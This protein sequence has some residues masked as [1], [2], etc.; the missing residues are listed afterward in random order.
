V[1]KYL[2]VMLISGEVERRTVG[3]AKL[4][5]PSQRVP[6]SALLDYSS[7]YIIVLNNKMVI[8][9]INK[10]FID[11]MKIERDEII[12]QSISNAPSLIKDNPYIMGGIKNCLLNEA[13][14]SER[15]HLEMYNRVFRM[16]FLPTTFND[17]SQGATIM[18][19]D[20]TEERRTIQSLKESDI[21][22]H[23]FI[24]FSPYGF[25]LLDSEL[26]ILEANEAAVKLINASKE[27][28]IGETL[29][30]FDTEIVSSGRYEKYMQILEGKIPYFEIDVHGSPLLSNKKVH[31]LVFR[32]GEGIGLIIVDLTELRVW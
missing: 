20:V 6:V 2:D 19:E 16:Q 14:H 32:A 8:T 18:M 24:S 22:A 1:A 12:G 9:Q 5:Y 7:D 26:K 31:L 11:L 17:G 3:R 4:F 13:P 15:K 21:R 30:K 25:V 10:N 28:V 29:L 23:D 27:D